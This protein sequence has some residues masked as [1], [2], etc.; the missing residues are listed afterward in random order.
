MVQAKPKMS[1]HQGRLYDA[2]AIM[3]SLAAN[4]QTWSTGHVEV[5]VGGKSC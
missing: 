2:N 4:L 3:T 5:L 1:S